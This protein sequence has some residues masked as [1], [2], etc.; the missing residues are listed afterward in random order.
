MKPEKL[1][2]LFRDNL[3][4]RRHAL[5]WT[6]KDLADKIGAHQPYIADLEKGERHPTLETLAKLSEA[7]G[8]SPDFF[9]S[10]SRSKIPA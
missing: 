6:Q 5:G 1:K 2:T 9:L 4:S 8:V 10:R 3:R 7:M